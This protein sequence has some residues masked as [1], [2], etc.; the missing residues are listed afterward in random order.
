MEKSLQ[1]IIW[2]LILAIILFIA[3]W[4]TLL[5]GLGGFGDT[6]KFQFVGHVLGTP[7]TSGYPTYL[8]LNKIF[9]HI[10]PFGSLAFKSNLLSSLF[11]ISALLF[12]YKTLI[13]LKIN[14]FPAFISVLSLGFSVTLWTQSIIAEVYTLHLLFLSAIIYQLVK[15]RETR[16]KK[17]LLIACAIYSFSFGNH[18]TSILFLPAFTY[19]VLANNPKIFRNKQMILS[20]M[21][22]VMLGALQYLYPFWRWYSPET[23]YLEMQTPD[24]KSFWWYI[25]GAQFSWRFFPY[26]LSQ[27]FTE[28]IPFLIESLFHQYFWIW[29]LAIWGL[30]K[31][32][33]KRITIFFSL[34]SLST[35]IFTL[36]YDI[37]D[38]IVY[39]I[40]LTFIGS[41]YLAYGLQSITEYCSKKWITGLILLFIPA[42]LLFSNYT[43]V[44]L[45]K[46]SVDLQTQASLA[47]IENNSLVLSSNYTQST[48][49]WYYLIG[50]K[51]GEKRNIFVHHE[52]ID[53]SL[54]KIYSYLDEEV[55][56]DLPLQRTEA[57]PSLNL[58]IHGED[59]HA[60]LTEKGYSLERMSPALYK[61]VK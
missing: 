38:I 11:S 19:W 35:L 46:A 8:L 6:A 16:I 55:P 53:V 30:I 39:F 59:L 49:W 4:M 5:P 60:A 24:L 7:H 45:S 42:N 54:P 47:L 10:F 9:T 58:Y 41:F 61:L 29:A 34:F 21:S 23:S 57:S 52:S 43:L 40:P 36:N 48:Y 13:R 3:Y 51:E 56:Y 18:L 1:K 28:R 14:P 20:I 27:F 32:F 12:F 44:D 31:N 37:P 22:I 17:D 33:R 26:S 50:L 15:W 25:S 2:P